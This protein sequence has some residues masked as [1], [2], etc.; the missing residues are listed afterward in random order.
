M[1]LQNTF[2]SMLL[3]IFSTVLF[4]NI[5]SFEDVDA[6][7]LSTFGSE[8]SGNGEFDSQN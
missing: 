8:G 7:T 5:I 4:F 2:K 1:K 6:I 3:I